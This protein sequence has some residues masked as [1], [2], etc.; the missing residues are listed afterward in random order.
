MQSKKRLSLLQHLK[1][2]EW[3]AVFNSSSILI[4]NRLRLAEIGN[5]HIGQTGG[6]W[7]R[8]MSLRHVKQMECLFSHM[9]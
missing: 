2:D 4:T 6:R 3:L 7:I 5:L 8:L 1:Q 9:S